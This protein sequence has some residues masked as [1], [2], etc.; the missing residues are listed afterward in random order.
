[1]HAIP[2]PDVRDRAQGADA[3]QGHLTHAGMRR[4]PLKA[5]NCLTGVLCRLVGRH[6]RVAH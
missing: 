2:G 3:V 4:V 6:C 5:P 1:M